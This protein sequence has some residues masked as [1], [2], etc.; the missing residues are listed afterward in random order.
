VTTPD[1]RARAYL[2][3]TLVDVEA[4]LADLRCGRPTRDDLVRHS[5]ALAAA[6]FKAYSGHHW[7]G[8]GW[9]GPIGHPGFDADALGN[10]LVLDPLEG[11]WMP[12]ETGFVA[13]AQNRTRAF[14]PACDEPRRGDVLR[15][16]DWFDWR[17]RL[18]DHALA[19][20]T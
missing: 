20:C 5:F 1:E 11:T 17:Y 4:V 15:F 7:R 6:G 12:E 19:R 10:V 8:G 16:V 9:W 2:E 3:D 18:V 13:P 14:D